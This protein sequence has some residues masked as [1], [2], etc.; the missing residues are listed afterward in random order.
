MMRRSLVPLLCLAG[1]LAC[2]MKSA[3]AEPPPGKFSDTI[4]QRVVACTICHGKQGEGSTQNEYYPRIG[5]KPAGYIYHQLV[6][7]KE[8]RRSYPE[9]VY[10]VQY[11]PDDYLNEIADYFSKQQPLVPTPT[12]PPLPAQALRRGQEL[13]ERGDSA[14]D[15]P[16]CT[17]CH[18][19]ALTGLQ[20]GIP[21]LLG[22]YPEYISAQLSAWRN[23]ARHANAPDCMEEIASRLSGADIT[24]IAGWLSAQPGP[25]AAE[26]APAKSQKLPLE[27]G[28]QPQ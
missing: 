25:A 10:L 12:K 19:K 14:R 21:G 24:A 7:F 5:G 8:G 16:A 22:L 27:C 28:S 6:N 13:V 18:G 26:P 15:I 2:G 11:L 9:M 3:L 23:G 4:A 17:A 20:P 1:W